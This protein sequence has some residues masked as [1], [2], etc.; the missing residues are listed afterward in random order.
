MPRKPRSLWPSV[1]P[2]EAT[3]LLA[4]LEKMEDRGGRGTP[5]FHD[6]S[7]LAVDRLDELIW[8]Q[9]GIVKADLMRYYIQ[10]ASYLLPTVADRPLTYRPYPQG[11]KQRPDRYHQRVKHAVPPGVRV[12]TFQGIEK[13]YESRFIGGSLVTLL[14]LVQIHVISIDP[15]LSRVE[16]PDHPDVAVIDLDPMEGVG[17]EHV[18][19][20]A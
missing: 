10:I 20:V 8:P 9:L 11:L 17:F 13:H 16:A 4:Q 18:K 14:Y 3:D 1:P 7:A 12:E 19:D 5:C 6:G 15:W 2:K